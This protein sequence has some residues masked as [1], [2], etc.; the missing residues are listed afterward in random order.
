[1][2]DTNGTCSQDEATM[3]LEKLQKKYEKGFN[4]VEMWSMDFS[5]NS[6]GSGFDDWQDYLRLNRIHHP[7]VFETW[8]RKKLLTIDDRAT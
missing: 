6:G 5:P 7:D 1:M 2:H 3:K 8:D 4:L